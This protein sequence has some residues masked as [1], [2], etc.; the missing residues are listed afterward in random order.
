MSEFM[1]TLLVAL[2]LS[3]PLVWVWLL[4]GRTH[5]PEEYLRQVRMLT[6]LFIAIILTG[7]MTLSYL[8]GAWLAG[9]TI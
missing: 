8:L 2:A 5:S 6:G 7:V 1:I 4:A 3:V 9:K